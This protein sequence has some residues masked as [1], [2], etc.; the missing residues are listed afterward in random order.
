[1]TFPSYNS[2][3][4]LENDSL[5]EFTA[6]LSM[7]ITLSP[8][9]VKYKVNMT[10]ENRSLGRQY[11]ITEM[12][13]GDFT[14]QPIHYN[15]TLE[16]LYGSDVFDLYMN[17]TSTKYDVSIDV[18]GYTVYWRLYISPNLDTSKPVEIQVELLDVKD[19]SVEDDY[20]LEFIEGDCIYQIIGGIQIT[21]EEVTVTARI[22]DN[23]DITFSIK[24]IETGNSIN[25]LLLHAE[26]DNLDWIIAVTDNNGQYTCSFSIDE[27]FAFGEHELRII[28]SS[29]GEVLEIITFYVDRNTDVRQEQYENVLLTLAA[30]LSICAIVALFF[31]GIMFKRE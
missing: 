1:M 12:I 30:I 10:D 9:L 23:V 25:D 6:P 11:T 26:I 20:L 13:E 17:Q 29:T 4:I 28:K 31:A 16:T 22:Y 21:V 3:F 15:E 19:F 2:R 8:I 27:S 18:D 5:Q 14:I 7:N 24:L